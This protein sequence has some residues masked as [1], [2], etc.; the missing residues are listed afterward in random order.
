MAEEISYCPSCGKE[1]RHDERFCSR[2]GRELVPGPSPMFP[3]GSD[4]AR[5]YWGFQW[6]T[7]AEIMGWPI[8]H[9]AIGRDEV[10]GKLLVARGLIAVGQFGVGLITVAQV[11]VGLLFGFGQF[12]VG[13]ICIGQFALGALFGLGQFATGQTAIGQFALGEYIRAQVGWGKYMWTQ[14]VKD[15]EAVAYFTNL[16]RA[17]RAFFGA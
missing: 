4:P 10:T 7:E 11:G 5:P 1:R 13:F 8:V 12:V 9:V 6:R 2:C 14:K 17:I 3:M 16:W 15:P